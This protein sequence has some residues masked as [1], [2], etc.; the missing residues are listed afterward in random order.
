MHCEHRKQ[1]RLQ[2]PSKTVTAVLSAGSWDEA[3][4]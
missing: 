1:L 2:Q 4:R 3:V